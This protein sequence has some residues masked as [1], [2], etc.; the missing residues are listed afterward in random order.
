MANVK[1]FAAGAVTDQPMLD[2]QFTTVHWVAE[3]GAVVASRPIPVTSVDNPALATV[4]NT[5]DPTGM[6]AK[7]SGIKGQAGVATLTVSYMN[8]DGTP[9]TGTATVT[10]TLDPAELDVGGFSATFDAPQ[11]QTPA[12]APT[13]SRRP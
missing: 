5:V 6:S 2:D 13:A 1:R 11:A 9:A 8:A 7:V 3:G 10:L 12:A 4:D